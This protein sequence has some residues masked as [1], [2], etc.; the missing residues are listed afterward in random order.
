MLSHIT[1][2]SDKKKRTR[3]QKEHNP[4]YF[5]TY[6]KNLRHNSITHNSVKR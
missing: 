2:L 6:M 3:E 4:K 1:I 5:K